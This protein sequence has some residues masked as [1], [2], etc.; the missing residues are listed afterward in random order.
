MYLSF[1]SCSVRTVPVLLTNYFWRIVLF[2]KP[3]LDGINDTWWGE[4]ANKFHQPTNC[5]ASAQAS[6][7]ACKQYICYW[8]VNS[9]GGQ[10]HQMTTARSMVSKTFSKPSFRF[11][12]LQRQSWW[13]LLW[14]C[15]KEWSNFG[16]YG[17]QCWRSTQPISR[18]KYFF[19]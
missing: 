9:F 3:D 11:D 5:R 2:K 6:R 13:L 7:S 1:K 15:S 8:G 4:A 19:Q 17:V 16:I 12:L 14:I 18:E 10:N